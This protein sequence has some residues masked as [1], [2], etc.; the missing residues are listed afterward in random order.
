MV[1]R[2]AERLSFGD[3]GV[4]EGGR[5]GGEDVPGRCWAPTA[6]GLPDIAAPTKG[7][8]RS[9]LRRVPS[10]PRSTTDRADLS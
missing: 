6:Q 8:A 3:A 7:P 2:G 4:D 10:Q 9:S 1:G 5:A